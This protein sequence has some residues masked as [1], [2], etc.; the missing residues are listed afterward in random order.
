MSI[1]GGLNLFLAVGFAYSYSNISG[2][3]VDFES[4]GDESFL[5][6]AVDT[7]NNSEYSLRYALQVLRDACFPPACNVPAVDEGTTEGGKVVSAELEC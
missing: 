1:I 7:T 6:Y 2:V 5:V 4:E 3:M